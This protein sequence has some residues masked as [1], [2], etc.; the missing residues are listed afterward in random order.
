MGTIAIEKNV[1]LPAGTELKRKTLYPFASMK[2]GDSFWAENGKSAISAAVQWSKKHNTGT[3]F[4]S[5]PE[6][7]NTVN[8]CRIWRIK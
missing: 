6:V 8:G 3:E 4:V 1:P 2:K 7:K 5:A